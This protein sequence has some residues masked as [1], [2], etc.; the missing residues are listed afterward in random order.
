MHK[1][2]I[3]ATYANVMRFA[4]GRFFTTLR[5][6]WLPVV[7]LLAV[8]VAHF[9]LQFWLM[10]VPFPHNMANADTPFGPPSGLDMNLM[11]AN[12]VALFVLQL[13][14]MSA[15]AVSIHRVILFGDTKPGVWLNFPFG[16]T[17]IRFLAMGLLFALMTIAVILIVVS[18]V[19]VLLSGGDV[20]AFFEGFGTKEKVEELARGGGIFALIAAYIAG[21]I[22]VLFMMVRLAVWPP[23]IVATGSLSPAEPWRLTRGNFWSLIGLF[24]LVGVTMYAVMIPFGIAMAVFMFTHMRDLP[25][26][27]IPPE[28]LTEMFQTALPFVFAFYF[29]LIV[30]VTGV[31]VA[32]LSYAY[33]ALKGIDAKDPVAV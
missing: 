32:T 4:F 28:R 6:T 15:V 7:L 10:G 22:A 13:I 31:T 29:V 5:L 9:G 20:V 3:A 33:K 14:A 26:G 24:I 27:Q 1:L 18:P 21:W 2:P 30:F 23:S 19:I 12:Q 8:I 11:I 25:A 17:E 16:A